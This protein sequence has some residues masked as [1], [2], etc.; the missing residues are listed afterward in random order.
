LRA[1]KIAGVQLILNN[2]FLLLLALFALAGMAGKV[3]AVF[4]A[5]LWHELFHAGAA[6]LLGYRTREIELLPFGGIARIAYLGEAGTGEETLVALAGPVGSLLMGALIYV[7]AVMVIERPDFGEFYIRVNMMLALFNLLPALP[8]D[9]GRIARAWLAVRQG[10]NLATRRMVFFS[11]LISLLLLAWVIVDYRQHGMVNLTFVTA[12]V[13][14]GISSRQEMRLSGFR[15]MRLLAKKKAALSAGGVLAT[16]HYTV[17][18]SVPIRDIVR[19]FDADHYAIVVVVN[20]QFQIQGVLTET[21]VWEAMPAWGLFAA[22][23]DFL[24]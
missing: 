2:W 12:A 11:R 17:R 19:S 8:L 24:A 22:V 3:M 4:G 18:K 6:A 14:I 13:F 20:D 23:G 21:Q 10:Y 7:V 9:G 5:V 1:G 15:I 16:R